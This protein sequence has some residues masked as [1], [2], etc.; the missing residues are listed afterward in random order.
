MALGFFTLFSAALPAH[1]VAGVPKIIHHQGRLLDAAGNLLGGPLG[2]NY[3]FKFA[4]YDDATVGAPDA[5][6]WPAGAPSTMTVNV[7]NGI[8]KCRDR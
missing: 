8:Y 7:T 2:Q 3:C 6:V 4:I 1:A 5:K